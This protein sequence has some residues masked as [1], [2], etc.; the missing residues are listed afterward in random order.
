MAGSYLHVVNKHGALRTQAQIN[1]SLENGGDIV[2]AIEEMYGMLWFLAAGNPELIE[3]ARVNWQ[4]G[5]SMS[6]TKRKPYC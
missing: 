1:N 5:Y 2:E 4:V 3:L 6:P